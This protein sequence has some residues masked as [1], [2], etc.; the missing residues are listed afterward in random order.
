M[1]DNQT[2]LTL[3]NFL[4][5][6][7]EMAMND[8]SYIMEW[9]LD[10]E[11]EKTIFLSEDM[12]GEDKELQNLIENDTEDRFIPIPA[13]PSREGWEQME[14][15]I[16][17]LDDQDKKTRNLLLTTIQGKGAFGRFKD[18]LYSI[19]LQDRWFEFK[20]REDRK[21]ALD[22]LHSL[23]LIDANQVEEGMQMF[24]EQVNK[25]KKREKEITNMVKGKQV[26]CVDTSGHGDKLTIG[27]TYH[28]LDEQKQQ[29][30]IRVEDDR[31][32]VCWLPKSHFELTD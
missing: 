29:L 4:L 15:F 11:E 6:E 13:S 21:K 1:A 28:I 18:A 26:R 31:G 14:R 24:E 9:Y 19:G 32:K 2:T 3:S 23:D 12:Y 10:T 5:G 30:N 17:S 27:K 16:Q 22:W 8:N 20:N 25:R 7:I